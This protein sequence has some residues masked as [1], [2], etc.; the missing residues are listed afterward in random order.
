M[1]DGSGAGMNGE[2]SREPGSQVQDPSFAESNPSPSSGD[3]EQH[4]PEQRP[5]TPADF[6]RPFTEGAAE[7]NRAGPRP[8]P[9]RPVEQPSGRS[10]EPTPSAESEDKSSGERKRGWW[11]RVLS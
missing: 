3:S 2:Q 7:G 11:K 4:W 8:A 1:G 5:M 9:D 10:A 6:D